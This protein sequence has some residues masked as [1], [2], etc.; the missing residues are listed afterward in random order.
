M[1]HSKSKS[2][3]SILAAL[4]DSDGTAQVVD[5]TN[6]TASATKDHP[7]APEGEANSDGVAATAADTVKVG[8][9]D[10]ISATVQEEIAKGEQI[11]RDTEKMCEAQAACEHH[12]GEIQKYIDRNESVPSSMAKAIKVSLLR[13]DK[14]FF[15]QTVPSLEAF[16]GYVGRMT[17]SLELLD[18]LK[19]GSKVIGAAIVSAAEMKAS[20][21]GAKH[22]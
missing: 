1:S 13:H 20:L 3:S 18:K 11:D 21:K 4:E 19:A 6:A 7:A 14:N 10:M 17:V 12:I 2:L 22:G 8:D 15:A 9:S 16:D 5:V